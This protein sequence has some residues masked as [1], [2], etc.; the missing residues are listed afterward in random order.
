MWIQSS[1]LNFTQSTKWTEWSTQHKN[2]LIWKIMN[3]TLDK[4][5]HLPLMKVTCGPI[6]PFFICELCVIFTVLLRNTCFFACT[7]IASTLNAPCLWSAW[8][9][10]NNHWHSW[11]WYVF[12]YTVLTSHNKD[13]TAVHSYSS[14]KVGLFLPKFIQDSN[15]LLD[16]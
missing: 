7:Q 10:L 1:R 16:A 5:S 15:C 13:K 2:I 6:K 3:C 4:F 14:S 9:L 8:V 11:W 12:C